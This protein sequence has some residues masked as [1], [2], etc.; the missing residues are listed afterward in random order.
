MRRDQG[1]RFFGD[2]RNVDV[3][4][5]D[6][7]IF[8]QN[9]R[10]SLRY[11]KNNLN[12]TSQLSTPVE[13]ILSCCEQQGDG[14]LSALREHRQKCGQQFAS[15]DVGISHTTLRQNIELCIRVTEKNSIL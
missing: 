4:K 12:D 9:V 13:K 5:S 11:L 6:I 10:A 14:N 3:A 15:Q 7:R 1:Y 8:V 2:R